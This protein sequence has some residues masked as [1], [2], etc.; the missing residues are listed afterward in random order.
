[1]GDRASLG[2][3]GNLIDFGFEAKRLKTG[4]PVRVDG[5]SLD[6][7]KW[8]NKKVMIPGKFSFTDTP[9]L[10]KPAKLLYYLY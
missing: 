6:F 9:A 5:R 2:L 8:R 4:T 7:S 3:T 1:M 10:T